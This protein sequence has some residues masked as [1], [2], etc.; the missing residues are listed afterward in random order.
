MTITTVK[1][2]EHAYVA[3]KDSATR[4]KDQLIAI[5][6]AITD[7]LTTDRSERSYKGRR[8]P[9]ISEVEDNELIDLLNKINAE[10]GY[11]AR[12]L[13]SLG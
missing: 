9:D 1:E 6:K 3:W 5:K 10:L 11:S 13:P 8:L 12:P 7:I 2:A 4:D